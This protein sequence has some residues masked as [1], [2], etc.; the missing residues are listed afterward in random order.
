MGALM[1]R[2]L[3]FQP[4]TAIPSRPPSDPSLEIVEQA[5]QVFLKRE[6]IPHPLLVNGHAQ[7]LAAYLWPRLVPNSRLKTDEERIFEVEPGIKLL[8]RCRWQ[9]ARQQSPLI[10]LVHGLEGST[11]SRYMI[12]TADKAYNAGF[13]VVRLN[14]RNCGNTE[15]LTPTLYH[16]GL[17]NDFRAIVNE[18]IH[19]DG[20]RRIF[21][22][23]F[24][25]SGNIALKY[26]GE[27]GANSPP[28]LKGICAVSP[29]A[30]LKACADAINLRS[31]WL[32]RQSFM[33]S[34]RK[35]I[36]A[37]HKVYPEVYDIHGLRKIR[38]IR[39][40]DERYTSADGGFAGADDYY[41]KSS[42]LKL[43]GL[44]RKPSLIVHAQDDPF[45][46]F[47]P[48]SDA[49]I[50]S[51]KFVI[52]LA[53]IHGGHVGFLSDSAASEDRFWAENRIVDFCKM[54]NSD[55]SD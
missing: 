27:E 50:S 47:D 36:R 44:I 4:R 52:V 6:F 20:I 14:M 38:T 48:L 46:P 31:N 22:A 24:S 15:H 18:L 9:T 40:F 25:M 8:A 13:S 12:G 39:D 28:E 1:A 37:K 16:S 23:G 30:D 53:P 11:E 29:S 26:A 32:Y 42:A 19:V 51:N 43:I 21:V 10:I 55:S 7:T 34:L 2:K 35:R 33:A 5:R 3:S 41:E 49:G 54:V 17:S 45:V